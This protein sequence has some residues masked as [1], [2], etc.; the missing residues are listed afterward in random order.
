MIFIVFFYVHFSEFHNVLKS[1]IMNL[2]IPI[3]E[4][5]TTNVLFVHYNNKHNNS[6]NPDGLYCHE[7]RP[8]VMIDG[9]SIRQYRFAIL[10]SKEK[11][12]LPPKSNLNASNSIID[13]LP[14]TI[15]RNLL[16]ST[17]KSP[18]RST[19]PST[20]LSTLMVS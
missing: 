16:K 19:A 8:R 10:S 4:I 18:K 5:M 20:G 3:S 12:K 13:A 1:I 9:K 11:N 17:K 2:N 15:R 6:A 14:S 7:D